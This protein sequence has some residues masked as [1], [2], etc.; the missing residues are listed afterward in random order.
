MMQGRSWERSAW[1]TAFA[2][3]LCVLGWVEAPARAEDPRVAAEMTQLQGIWT[4]E[5]MEVDGT[6][7]KEEQVKGWMLVIQ[8]DQYNPGSNQTSVEYTYKVDP[9]LTPKSIDLI[10]HDGPYRN[11]SLKGVYVLKKDRLTICRARTPDGERPAGF[12]SRAES[13]LVVT[14]WKRR[15]GSP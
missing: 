9:S 8:G 7:A 6:K 1:A 10:P 15:K 4:L 14:V 3:S 5:S 12:S 13:G 2:L 11:R